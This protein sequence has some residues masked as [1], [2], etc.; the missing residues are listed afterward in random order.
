MSFS[1][2]VIIIISDVAG[3]VAKGQLDRILPVDKQ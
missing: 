3:I 2:A 1:A